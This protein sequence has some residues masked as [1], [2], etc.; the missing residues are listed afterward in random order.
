M[1]IP[2][3]FGCRCS[4]NRQTRTRSDGRSCR[5]RLSPDVDGRRNRHRQSV[6]C[7]VRFES[8]HRR[9]GVDGR[10]RSV[11]PDDHVRR[12]AENISPAALAEERVR[13]Q[14]DVLDDLQICVDRAG[15]GGSRAGVVANRRSGCGIRSFERADESTGLDVQQLVAGMAV[16]RAFED[17]V[18]MQIR[19]RVVLA[20]VTF[21]IATA[22]LLNCDAIAACLRPPAA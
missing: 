12:Q 5:P 17:D 10:K 21:P 14:L 3:S 13:D 6:L 9:V 18:R 7:D 8:V 22:L 16:V 4:K 20:P 2:E 19:G 11:R 1:C 15:Y